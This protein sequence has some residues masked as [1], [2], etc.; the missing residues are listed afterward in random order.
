MRVLYLEQVHSNR[1]FC[2]TSHQSLCKS[3]AMGLS[4]KTKATNKGT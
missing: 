2:R 3:N 4:S 1:K